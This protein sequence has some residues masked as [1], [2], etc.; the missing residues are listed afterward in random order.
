MIWVGYRR[1]DDEARKILEDPELLDELLE[2]DDD[3][4][5]VDLD[6]AWH[7]IHWLLTGSGEP[8]DD[9]A[10]NAIFGGEEIGEDLGYGPGRLLKAS[11]VDAVA[12]ALRELDPDT[13]GSRMDRA[14]MARADVYPSIWDEQDI[15][16]E[17]LAPAYERL[18][19]FY[20]AAAEDGTAIIQTIC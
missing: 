1:R 7:G 13:L 11:G 5:S 4:T 10:S 15:F 20:L 16:D 2:S 19:A 9:E 8:T 6:K 18:R 14:A 17:Y 3:V 12:N